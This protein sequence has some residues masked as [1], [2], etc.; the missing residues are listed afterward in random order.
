[1]QAKNKEE[2]NTVISKTI[3]IA[4]IIVLAG[5]ALSSAVW[6]APCSNAS[7]SGTYGFAHSGTA[8]DGTPIVGLSQVTFDPTT[9]TYTGEDMQSHNGVITT[10]PLTATYLVAPN[11][12]VTATVAVGGLSQ[13]IAFVVTSTGF[14]SLV[15]RTSV[16][17]EGFAVKQGPATCANARLEGSFGFEATGVFVAGAPTTG[18]VAFIGELKFAVKDSGEGEISGHMASSQDG[19]IL[20]FADEPV[21]GSYSV[22][23]DCTG[24]ATIKPKGGPELHFSLVVVDCGKQILAIETDANTV[25]SG[26]L[27]KSNEITTRG[28]SVRPAAMSNDQESRVVSAPIHSNCINSAQTNI[29]PARI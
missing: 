8:G 13:N 29:S 10:E 1:L 18:P 2:E 7:L 28:E 24:A 27:V 3:R 15:E 22:A 11:C 17:T 16:T 26:T 5:F 9:G 6:A 21:T 20:T 14:F 4:L 23:T 19:T 12:T 25:V